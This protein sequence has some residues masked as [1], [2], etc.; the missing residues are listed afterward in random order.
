[1]LINAFAAVAGAKKYFR[2]NVGKAV[3]GKDDFEKIP[4][5]DD[6]TGVLGAF[7]K[8]TEDYLVEPSTVTL[9]DTCGKALI[10]NLQ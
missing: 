9:L 8:M 1:M 4:E 7:K 3:E 10:A 6:I 5:M 2:F